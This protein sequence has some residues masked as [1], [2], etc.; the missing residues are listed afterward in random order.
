ML[1][2][3]KILYIFVFLSVFVIQ[4]E[5]EQRISLKSDEITSEKNQD[6]NLSLQYTRENNLVKHI[7]IQQ[8]HVAKTQSDRPNDSPMCYS[9]CFHSLR[10]TSFPMHRFVPA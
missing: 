4:T 6:S 8:T 5:K 9:L 3:I 7:S 10:F 1:S 2:K